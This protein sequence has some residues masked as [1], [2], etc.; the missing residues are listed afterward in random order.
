MTRPCVESSSGNHGAYAVVAIA[1]LS[2]VAPAYVCGAETTLVPAGATWRYLDNGSNQ[3]TAWRPTDFDDSSWSFGPAQLGY[4]D[5]GE[6]TVVSFGPN[7]NNKYITTYFRHKFNATNTAA[8]TTARLRVV[9]DDGVLVYLNGTEIYRNNMPGGAINYLTVASSTI[10]GAAESTFNEWDFDAG[11][12]MDGTNGLA[13]E[14]HQRS[15]TSS[16]ISFDLEL[17]VSTNSVVLTRGPYLQRSTTDSVIVRWQTNGVT[18]SRV[19]FGSAPGNLTSVADNAAVTTDHEVLVTGLTA[20]T[21][22]YYSIGSSTETL[23]GD[24]ADHFFHTHPTGAQPTRIWVIGDSGTADANAAAVRD[25]Y[26][27]FAAGQP[28]DVWLMLGDNAYNNGTLAEY[29]AAVFDMYPTVLRQT[30]VWPTL[31]NH[32][33]VSA[34]S[35]SESGVYYE[36]FTLPRAAE[37]GGWPS[38]TEAYYSFDY[39]NIH[40]VCLDSHDTNRS[41]G[42]AMMTWLQSDLADT[43]QEWIIAF[44]HH[45][46]YTKGSH[47]S[48]NS[49]DSGGRLRDMREIAL[50]I[51]EA[52]GVD[53]V[54]CG[55]S[56]SYERS[57]LLDG[58]YDVSTT[59]MPAMVLDD[60]DGRPDCDG[61]YTKSSTGPTGHEGAVYVVAGSSGKTSGGALNHPAMFISLNQLGSL[62]LDVDDNRLDASFVR[63]TGQISDHFSIVKGLDPDPGDMDRDGDVDD[64]DHARFEACIVGPGG[65]VGACCDN[66]DIDVDLD[67]DLADF[68]N[69]AESFTGG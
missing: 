25:A 56:H 1:C 7:A 10:G 27:T 11:L 40:F 53:L 41:V 2:A 8:L 21:T 68:S 51:L 34:D 64:L 16:D 47:N 44:W 35:P 54:L 28:T 31:G 59:L 38:G 43:T 46:P 57:F 69:F 6:A 20:D 32:D 15:G 60:G 55:H 52:G 61:A 65:G 39:G 22:Y 36:L 33:G 58:H 45:P 18:D 63:S 26:L 12:L 37:A 17:L 23:V 30:T 5:G 49:G 4:G 48:D 19:R 29:E 42:G 66:A 62:V 67:I 9:R 50:P 13:V 3:G 14:I 24:D